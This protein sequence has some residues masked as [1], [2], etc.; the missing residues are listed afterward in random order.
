MSTP[1]TANAAYNVIPNLLFLLRHTD[2]VAAA[3]LCTASAIQ[4]SKT[5]EE[6]AHFCGYR[7]VQMILAAQE[8]ETGAANIKIP[9]I[10]DLQIKI[11]DAW[12]AG[13]NPHGMAQTGGIRG[14]RK[15]IGTSEAEA[16]LLSL[17][18]PCTG[19]AFHGKH[20]WQQLLDYTEAYFST[21]FDPS[22]KM[23][24]SQEAH[25]TNKSPIFLQRPSHSLTIVGMIRFRS[26]KRGILTFDPAWQT[27]SL[28]RKPLSASQHRAW[29][30]KWLLKQYTKSER[31]LKRY[32]AFETLIIERQ[33]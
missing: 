32:P 20:A 19:S 28:M 15:H 27:P 16:L 14:T 17:G 23:S 33:G 11:E 7:N 31:Y 9:T 4:I 13:I 1:D 26:G 3:Y 5:L 21:S 12:K 2:D 10:S 8:H 25:L 22:V 29:K 30:L 18:I 24:G 6:G